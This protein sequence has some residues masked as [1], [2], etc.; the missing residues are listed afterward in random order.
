MELPVFLFPMQ[1]LQ[2]LQQNPQQSTIQAGHFMTDID[3]RSWPFQP[4]LSLTQAELVHK[5][6][7]LARNENVSRE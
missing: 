4:M 1:A 6:A 7:R 5:T 3:S 2:Y